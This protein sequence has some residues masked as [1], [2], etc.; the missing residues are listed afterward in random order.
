M[1]QRFNIGQAKARLSQLIDAALAGHDVVIARRNVPVVRLTAVDS[2][3]TR[4]RFGKL[5]GLVSLEPHFEEPL[6]DFTE[7]R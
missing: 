7:Y 6:S 5:A 4:P 3:K 2:A 1:E